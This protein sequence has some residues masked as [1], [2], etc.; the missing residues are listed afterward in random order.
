MSEPINHHYVSRC[1][2]N[3]FF[4]TSDKR[5]YVLDK[6]NLSIRPKQSTKT[7]FS[8]DDS[9]TRTN[10]DLS[11]NRHFLEADLKNVFEDHYEYHLSIIQRLVENPSQPPDDFRNSI[12]VLTKFGSIGEIRHPLHKKGTDDIIAEPL[13]NQI[14]PQAA[15][16][17]KASLL[18]LKDRLSRTKYSNSIQYSQHANQL[19]A[20]MG[21]ITSLIYSIECNKYFLLP[22]ISA[23]RA[24]AKINTYF[25]PDIREIAM[26]GMPLTSKLYMH[27]QSI[28]LGTTLD[29]VMPVDEEKFPGEVERINYG[30]FDNAY[31]EV[32]CESY[33][34]LLRFRDNLD[35]IKGKVLS[36]SGG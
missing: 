23:I 32:A 5:I 11:T 2:S 9:N 30:L 28:K 21:D 24:R 17:L 26:V 27:S 25:N 6:S 29:A 20:L 15:P 12:V 13:F 35:M 4:N 19:F 36:K 1:Q 34:Y 8:E 18:E 22:D 10:E 7:L 31:R 3:R 16:E 33:D 14:L